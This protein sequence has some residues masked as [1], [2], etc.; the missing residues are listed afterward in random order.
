[1]DYGTGI[2]IKNCLILQNRVASRQRGFY[3][4]KLP[5]LKKYVILIIQAKSSK[6]HSKKCHFLNVHEIFDP[7]H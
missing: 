3:I 6:Q 1:V 4:A 7:Q 2:P 5:P